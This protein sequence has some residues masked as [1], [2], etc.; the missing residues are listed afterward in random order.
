MCVDVQ[1]Y[2]GGLRAHMQDVSMIRNKIL[3][4]KPSASE[5]FGVGGAISTM[6]S[7]VSLVI[8]GTKNDFSRNVARE[9]GA[10][11]AFDPSSVKIANAK[12]KKNA[13]LSGGAIHGTF[14]SKSLE[15]TLTMD[16]VE[17]LENTAFIG[18]GL[19]VDAKNANESFVP[20][21]GLSQSVF[22]QPSGGGD[23]TIQLDLSD[24]AFRGQKTV[25]DGGGMLLVDVHAS[26]TRCTFVG[27]KVHLPSRFYYMHQ[28]LVL[29]SLKTLLW[30]FLG[31]SGIL[32]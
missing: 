6:G 23:L 21:D 29:F 18:G 10:I 15:K 7:G 2:S 12:F 9:G 19:M 4:P 27:N 14:T 3:G 1:S 31:S 32:F 20:E 16:F 30:K 11:R 8:N 28:L 25:Q 26:C 13:A 17:F 24:I 22:L 5:K